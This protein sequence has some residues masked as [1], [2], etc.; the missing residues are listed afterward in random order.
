MIGSYDSVLFQQANIPTV[1]PA[2][3]STTQQNVEAQ[4]TQAERELVNQVVGPRGSSQVS[5]F[6]ASPP[7]PPH[8]HSG[9]PQQDWI[10][11]GR[12]H[13]EF[14][15]PGPKGGGDE[16]ESSPAA[17]VFTCEECKLTMTTKFGLKS[18][19]KF[20]C[21]K[22]GLD[23]LGLGHLE[24]AHRTGRTVPSEAL[25][26]DATTYKCDSEM[27]QFI[28]T[29]PS[30]YARFRLS[31][32]PRN[33]QPVAAFWPALFDYRGKMALT[34]VE[35]SICAADAYQILANILTDG[36]TFY[37]VDSIT[38]KK[39]AFVELS[40]GDVFDISQYRV[41]R[42]HLGVNEGAEV[43][44]DRPRFNV[45]ET[46]TEVKISLHEK[47][48]Q[49]LPRIY[50]STSQSGD[51]LEEADNGDVAD[52]E[53][54]GD[55]DLNLEHMYE[56]EEQEDDEEFFSQMSEVFSQV[57]LEDTEESLL[58]SPAVKRMKLE[59]VQ[60]E[61]ELEE[62]GKT[63]R[64]PHCNVYIAKGNNG[65][66]SRH[67]SKSCPESPEID[68]L[69]AMRRKKK[70]EKKLRALEQGN[71]GVK[72]EVKSEIKS[73]VKS[74]VKPELKKEK[75]D[76]DCP[77]MDHQPNCLRLRGGAG[78]VRLPR[79]I[80]A[81]HLAPDPDFLAPHLLRPII[82][83]IQALNHKFSNRQNR[84]RGHE[85]IHD[86]IVMYLTINDQLIFIVIINILSA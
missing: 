66:L 53:C 21:P 47:Y 50:R 55:E 17:E 62:Q 77:G 65:N 54:D 72:S 64:C 37:G 76:C 70:L 22:R 49:L 38:Y 78:H 80:Q 52:H 73:E 29:H 19:Q 67:I 23:H 12:T 56:P 57:A 74:E 35:S 20:F 48:L 79:P 14:K 6:P 8:I 61:P 33:P 83:V 86:N 81:P 31:E 39:R 34:D 84:S 68:E 7:T 60:Q 58:S 85:S 40:N 27:D 69:E 43:R 2:P 59:P 13:W 30:A 15:C 28:S 82:P 75:G 16:P 9:I 45:T 5:N 1:R 3:A 42:T 24:A 46:E 51:Y 36:Y 63:N 26:S 4:N 10:V 11:Q 41:P 44:L 18:H 71:G 32:N 25:K